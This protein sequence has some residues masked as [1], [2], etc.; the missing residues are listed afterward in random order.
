MRLPASF[1]SLPPPLAGEFLRGGSVVTNG[2]S[3][4]Q[5]LPQ[6]KLHSGVEAGEKGHACSFIERWSTR[7]GGTGCVLCNHRALVTQ[8]VSFGRATS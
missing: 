2:T 5:A 3:C 8:G 7:L 1:V 4:H 6:G